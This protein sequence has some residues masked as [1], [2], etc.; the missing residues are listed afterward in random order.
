M[1]IVGWIVLGAG[2]LI[3]VVVLIVAKIKGWDIKANLPGW[4]AWA[5]FGAVLLLVGVSYL[6]SNCDSC[7]PK[8]EPPPPPEDTSHPHPPTDADMCAAAC[9][10]MQELKCPE[11][12][13]L[14]DGT[15]CANFCVKTLGG[16]HGLNP[17]CIAKIKDCAGVNAC[18]E[19]P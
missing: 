9:A 12:E 17:T 18:T 19:N 11:A 8:E 6:T 14:P 4:P 3:M 10:R 13:P 2:V 16:G 5:G 15:T 7:D 1:D